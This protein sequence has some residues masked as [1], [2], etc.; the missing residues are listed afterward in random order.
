MARR[1]GAVPAG[2]GNIH[3]RRVRRRHPRRRPHF[4]PSA[5]PQRG[6]AG[7]R[8]HR[9]GLRRLLSDLGYGHH[10]AQ[11]RHGQRS[12]RAQ[13]DAGHGTPGAARL[14]RVSAAGTEQRAGLRRRRRLPARLPARLSG[15]GAN[16][17]AKFDDAWDAAGRL[18][19]A[20]GRVVTDMV[21]SIGQPGGARCTL[22]ARTRWS[23]S[24]ACAAPTTGSVAWTFW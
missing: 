16:A 5:G 19:G 14:R 11:Q 15:P 18:P 4:R 12:Q 7:R 10:P 24:R 6:R 22:P 21:E 2:T 20:P 3:Y 13:P 23:A 1:G 9:P 17:R 8:R